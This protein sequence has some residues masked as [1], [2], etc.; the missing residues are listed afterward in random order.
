MSLIC[1]ATSTSSSCSKSGAVSGVE[2]VWRD[3]LD[4]ARAA[5][6]PEAV[7]DAIESGDGALPQPYQTVREVMG[8]GIQVQIRP[9]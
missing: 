1:R 3:H 6:V 5:G 8:L 9:G 7:I 4:K 2:F